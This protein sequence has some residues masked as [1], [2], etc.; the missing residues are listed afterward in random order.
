[1]K[2]EALRQPKYYIY[3]ITSSDIKSTYIH[4]YFSPFFTRCLV[5]LTETLMLPVS[6]H[7]FPIFILFFRTL[8]KN[9]V[10]TPPAFSKSNRDRHTNKSVK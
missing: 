3:L 1:M 10:D 8:L 2:K 5:I 6:R 4:G 7:L 9:H